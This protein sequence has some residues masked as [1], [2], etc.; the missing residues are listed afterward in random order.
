MNKYKIADYL[1]S[2][3][4]KEG[5]TQYSLADKLGCKRDLIAAYEQKKIMYV[6]DKLKDLL[7]PV[8]PAWVNCDEWK[9]MERPFESKVRKRCE[10]HRCFNYTV[11]K[12]M[13][14]SH[15]RE[16]LKYGKI[17]KACEKRAPKGEGHKDKQGY[18]RVGNP[19]TGGQTLK[20]R[21]VMAEHLGRPLESFE[22]VHHINGVRDDNRLENLELWVKGQPT[23]VRKEDA[24]KYAKQ[25]LETY[26]YKVT[27]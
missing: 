11:S 26:G 17:R 15:Y 5:L 2:K 4:E 10:V 24:I 7:L 3:R 6:S 8:F 19:Y 23:G 14:E 21:L 12:N 13:C 27:K 20:H 18:I 9:K 25:I 16:F 1:K 22:N